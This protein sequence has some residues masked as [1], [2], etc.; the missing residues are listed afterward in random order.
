MNLADWIF[1]R[2]A[3]TTP[4]PTDDWWYGRG[5]STAG[6]Y[7]GMS[8]TPDLALQLST[9]HACVRLVSAPN[10]ARPH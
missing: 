2:S 1:E 3:A 5:P 6:T 9:I 10:R 8:V 4:G 7:A